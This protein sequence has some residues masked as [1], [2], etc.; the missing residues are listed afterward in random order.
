MGS[1]DS[2]GPAACSQHQGTSSI[3][4]G[5]LLHPA[6][7]VLLLM[8]QGEGG[9]VAALGH[10]RALQA[11]VV[12]GVEGAALGLARSKQQQTTSPAQSPTAQHPPSPPSPTLPNAAA[13]HL[14]GK[15]GAGDGTQLDD[16][17]HVGLLEA[18]LLGQRQACV[19]RDGGAD[20]YGRQKDQQAVQLQDL[21]PAAQS[22]NQSVSDLTSLRQQAP[23][24]T[25]SRTLGV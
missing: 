5:I 1:F 11:E 9:R 13:P 20:G 21:P 17:N 6:P 16:F 10:A 22:I 7:Q 19:L 15:H 4:A 14:E 12:M 3:Q 24:P 2:T 23:T 8:L 25:P 18:R